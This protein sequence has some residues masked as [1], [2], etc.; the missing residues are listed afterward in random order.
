M[1]LYS[2][3]RGAALYCKYNSNNGFYEPI[4]HKPFVTS[5]IIKSSNTVDI[6]KIYSKPSD[7]NIRLCE[8]PNLEVYNTTFTNPLNFNVT[9]DDVALFT[10]LDG[11]WTIYSYN[12][13]Q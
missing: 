1:G 8:D 7:P 9:I 12:P 6:Y 13:D 2:A 10:F 11:S 4:G 5:G 3:P